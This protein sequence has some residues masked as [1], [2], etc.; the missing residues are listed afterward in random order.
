MVAKSLVIDA[1]SLIFG[2]LGDLHDI[3][4]MPRY[5][6]EFFQKVSSETF[7]MQTVKKLTTP[8]PW[9]LLDCLANLDVLRKH[10]E[11]AAKANQTV[12]AAPIFSCRDSPTD[13]SKNVAA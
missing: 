3:P 5:S 6:Q 4:T 8:A 2:L 11:R 13:G 12:V 1:S 7:Q 9:D 10:V